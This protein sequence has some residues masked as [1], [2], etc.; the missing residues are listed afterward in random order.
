MLN[1]DG[2]IV[3]NCDNKLNFK[4]YSSKSQNKHIASCFREYCRI[5]KASTGYLA[6]N[7]NLQQHQRLSPSF[8]C[9]ENQRA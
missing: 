4:F 5:I 1:I 2:T 8:K 3:K 9:P 7:N 6:W